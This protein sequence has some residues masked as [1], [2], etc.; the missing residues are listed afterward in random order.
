MLSETSTHS[1]HMLCPLTL[2]HMVLS[3]ILF[4]MVLSETGTFTCVPH[5]GEIKTLLPLLRINH[6]YQ[7]I[8]LSI[9]LLMHAC[10]L[11]LSLLLRRLRLGLH[12][13]HLWRPFRRPIFT[14][15][16]GKRTHTSGKANDRIP[17]HRF[18]LLS[19][20]ELQSVLLIA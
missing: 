10:G 7:R 14:R 12:A 3:I 17:R 20:A 1:T 11:D 18:P 8:Y 2:L 6:F 13:A 15:C 4:H 16:N 19:Q 9:I 5:T